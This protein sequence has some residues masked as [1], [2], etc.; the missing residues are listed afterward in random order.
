MFSRLIRP[1]SFM[2]GSR[3]PQQI[4]LSFFI[5]TDSGKRIDLTPKV[6]KHP[7]GLDFGS[8]DLDIGPNSMRE[9]ELRV[10]LNKELVPGKYQLE[11]T[12]DF[13]IPGGP[14]TNHLVSNPVTI[15]VIQSLF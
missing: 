3:I 10:I 14:S 5:I 8:L 13:Q 7:V 2:L 1:P 9:S 12:R 11:L 6:K 15:Q 4:P